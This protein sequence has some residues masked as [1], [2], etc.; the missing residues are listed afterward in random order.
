MQGKIG[1]IE[2]TDKEFRLLSSYIKEC[3]GINIVDAKKALLVGR[4]SNLLIELG[5]K[6]F[7][8]YYKHLKETNDVNEITRLMDRITTNHTFF[9][10]EPEHFNYF[11]QSVLP[12]LKD[13]V[14]NRDLRIWCAASATGEEPYTLAILLADYFKSDVNIWDK[15]ILATDISLNALEEAKRGLYSQESVKNLPKIWLLNYFNKIGNDTFQVKDSLKSQVIFRQ[16]NLTENS[17]PFKKKLHVVFC[18]NV[19]IYFD[20]ETKDRLIE[21]IYDSMEYGGYLFIGHSE[22]INREKSGFKFVKPAVYRKM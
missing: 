12:Y 3:S 13:T 9:L 1:M 16:F 8:S 20:N 19:M 7:M 2:I 4:L 11:S 22:S 10:R 14:K 15:R 21:K 17:F 5:F 18:R 6:D